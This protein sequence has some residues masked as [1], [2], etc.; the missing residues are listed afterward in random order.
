MAALSL[1]CVL[2]LVLLPQPT[3]ASTYEVEGAFALE[4]GE[5]E[6]C[7]VDESACG[8]AERRLLSVLKANVSRAAFDLGFVR[9]CVGFAA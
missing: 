1:C 5:E 8:D 9:A 6:G 7:G 3:Q 4:G 2:A